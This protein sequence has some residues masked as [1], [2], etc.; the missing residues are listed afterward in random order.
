[1][2]EKPY[3]NPSALKGKPLKKASKFKKKKGNYEKNPVRML[4]WGAI[5]AFILSGL[6]AVK[7]SNTAIKEVHTYKERISKLEST[8]EKV[9]QQQLLNLPETNAALKRFLTL[10]FTIPIERS[11]QDERERSLQGYNNSL[12]FR[13]VNQ[14]KESQVVSILENYGYQE[15]NGVTEATFYLKTKAENGQENESFV[16]VRFSQSKKGYTIH[17]LPNQLAYAPEKWIAHDKAKT[18]AVPNQPLDDKK[19]VSEVKTFVVQFLKEYQ[20]NN[21]ENLRYLMKDVQ[22]LPK[23]WTIHSKELAI[24]GESKNPVVTTTLQLTQEKTDI[25][26]SETIQ[27]HLTTTED[28]KYFINEMTYE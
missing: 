11:K 28:G 22:G 5:L 7:N 16:T 9:S 24:Y 15:R 26:L 13:L 14:P 19:A 3:F 18:T 27:L 20:E 2:N 12:S 10:Y 6:L 4:I 17:S 1:M 25:V 21:Q 8:L 23:G